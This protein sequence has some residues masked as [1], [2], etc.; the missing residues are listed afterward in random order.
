VNEKT[1]EVHKIHTDDQVADIF[2][3]PMYGAKLQKFTAQMLGHLPRDHA[4]GEL[5]NMDYQ[6]DME[7]YV[8]VVEIKSSYVK[9]LKQV[10]KAND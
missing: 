3:K 1:V 9:I 6:P 5:V 4:D 7:P 8:P 10:L 2:T